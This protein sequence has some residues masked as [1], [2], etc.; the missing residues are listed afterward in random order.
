[1]IL[2]LSSSD[3]DAFQPKLLNPQ[4]LAFVGDTVVD[5][6]VR[7]RLCRQAN[8]PRNPHI[9]AARI[10]SAKA[11]AVAMERMLP[12]L[13]EEENTFYRRGKNAKPKSVPHGASKTEYRIA[14]GLETLFG[15]LYFTNQMQRIAELAVFLTELD[16]GAIQQTDCI[17]Y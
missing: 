4:M 1:M 6:I 9:A 16:D 5:L 12:H 3:E 2:N 8:P 7:E 17:A 11:Q 10:V 14:T 15:W 13:T